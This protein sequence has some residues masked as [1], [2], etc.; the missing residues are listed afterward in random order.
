MAKPSRHEQ[1]IRAELAEIERCIVLADARYQDA[2]AERA[3]L[4]AQQ[5]MLER[6]LNVGSED[7][8]EGAE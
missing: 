2:V 7:G 1:A 4:G 6:L 8:K 5:A 3:A